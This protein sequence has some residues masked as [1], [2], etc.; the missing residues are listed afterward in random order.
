MTRVSYHQ[1]VF[2]LLDLDPVHLGRRSSRGED[3][4]GA[5][6]DSLGEWYGYEAAVPASGRIGEELWRDRHYAA[7][8]LWHDFSDGDHP[9]SWECL[10]DQLQGRAVN[11]FSP[12]PGH[13]YVL[14]DR[15]GRGNWLVELRGDDPIVWRDNNARSSSAWQRQGPFSTFLFDWIAG[16]YR[17]PSTPLSG[18]RGYARAPAGPWA[19]RP[20]KYLE[21]VWLRAPRE[22]ALAPPLLDLLIES[23]DD[24]Q[25]QARPDGPTTHRF[26][27]PRMALTVTTDA[28]GDP[29]GHSAWWLHAQTPE[30]LA[31]LVRR[32]WPIGNLADTLQGPAEEARRVLQRCRG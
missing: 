28:W 10:A 12:R 19:L 5:L 20:K 2:D 1:N 21:G 24:E 4:L 26:C 7:G 25:R 17:L 31:E 9:W 29:E 32:V 18:R 16:F 8:H 13:L 30:A 23:F 6:P 11:G 15:L 14:T 3:T 22:P 27:S